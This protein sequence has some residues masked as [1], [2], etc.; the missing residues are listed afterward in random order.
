MATQLRDGKVL[1]V[2]GI[3]V[4]ENAIKTAEIFDPVSISKDHRCVQ[5]HV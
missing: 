4:E 5:L 3:D 1:I 2:G